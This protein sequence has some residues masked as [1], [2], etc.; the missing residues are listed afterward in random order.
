MVDPTEPQVE[1]DLAV[2]RA[3]NG[4]RA[5]VVCAR[6]AARQLADHALF[7][8]VACLGCVS[9]A[10]IVDQFAAGA[11]DVLL[12]DGDCSTCKYR[13]VDAS[14]DNV[15]LTANALLEAQGSPLRAGRASEFPEDM[16]VGETD[17]VFGS[18]RRGFFSD[19]MKAAREMAASAADAALKKELG[20]MTADDIGKRLHV[21]EDGTLP[22]IAVPRHERL[23]NGLF[24]LGEASR[25]ET[26]AEDDRGSLACDGVGSGEAGAYDAR[27]VS[28]A[29]HLFGAI[30]IDTTKCNACGMCAVFCPTSAIRR[31]PMRETPTA[32]LKLLEFNASDCVQCGLCQD[33]CWKKCID[34]SSEVSLEQLFSF[35]PK[36][37]S[38]Q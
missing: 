6:M 14:V 16:L 19:T 24:V 1:E 34:L 7:V 2:A 29:T 35:E 12:I 9:E 23:L 25:G 33:V 26:L 17:G 4:G 21:S 3:K 18:T 22:S 5:A 10:L 27:G 31:D 37:F 13:F 30:D 32:R 8:E 28:V 36:V 20:A 15:V 11:A 38:L